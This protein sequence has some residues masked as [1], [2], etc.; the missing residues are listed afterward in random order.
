MIHRSTANQRK[1]QITISSSNAEETSETRKCSLKIP[2]AQ[3]RISWREKETHGT[4]W[5]SCLPAASIRMAKP[6]SNGFEA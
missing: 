5:V 6:F 1:N 4:T 3:T 2:E